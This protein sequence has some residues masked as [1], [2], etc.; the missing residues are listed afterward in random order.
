MKGQKKNTDVLRVLHNAG[1]LFPQQQQSCYLFFHSPSNQS[2]VSFVGGSRKYQTTDAVEFNTLACL[3]EGKNPKRMQTEG[4]ATFS[5]KQQG[6]QQLAAQETTGTPMVNNTTAGI[7]SSESPSTSQETHPTAIDTSGTQP[8]SVLKRIII[9]NARK[10]ALGPPFPLRHHYTALL[11][12]MR[13]SEQLQVYKTVSPLCD[14]ISYWHN[15]SIIYAPRE[16]GTMM[17]FLGLQFGQSEGCIT[18]QN[19]GA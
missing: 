3:L 11:P 5:S 17:K 18:L 13:A 10:P 9:G 7:S 14:K 19:T 4:S 1:L 15:A 12:S 6:Q 2:V 8:E 16:R